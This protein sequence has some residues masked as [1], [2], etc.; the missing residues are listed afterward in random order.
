M[1]EIEDKGAEKLGE[2]ISKLLYLTTLKLSF[3]LKFSFIEIIIFL[4]F[5]E[6][7]FFFPKILKTILKLLKSYKAKTE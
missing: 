1:N 6:L 3:G 7:L 5:I 4:F 2:S